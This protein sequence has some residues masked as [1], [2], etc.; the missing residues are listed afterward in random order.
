MWRASLSVSLCDAAEAS[1]SRGG[2]VRLGSISRVGFYEGCMHSPPC[3]RGGGGG[4]TACAQSSDQYLSRFPLSQ[5]SRKGIRRSLADNRREIL[6]SAFQGRELESR[7][8][9]LQPADR[10]RHQRCGFLRT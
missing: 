10:K 1:A 5:R 3:C 7:S 2:G 9:P 8:R 6:R 4:G